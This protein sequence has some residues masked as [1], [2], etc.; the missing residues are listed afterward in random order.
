MS[1]K[2][3]IK[4]DFKLISIVFAMLMGLLTIYV[5]FSAYGYDRNAGKIVTIPFTMMSG[6]VGRFDKN[7][8]RVA[9]DGKDKKGMALF[10]PHIKLVEGEYT[11]YFDY[12][13][14]QNYAWDIYYYKINR[15]IQRGVL[16]IA[17]NGEFKTVFR[18]ASEYTNKDF[19]FRVMYSGKGDFIAKSLNL[20]R[21][22]IVMKDTATINGMLLLL[23]VI[24]PFVLLIIYL[25][26]NKSEEKKSFFVASSLLIFGG[27][28]VLLPSMF[29]AFLAIV[30]ILY[31]YYVIRYKWANIIKKLNKFDYLLFAFM[32]IAIIGVIFADS[33]SDALGGVAVFLL[34][35]LLYIAFK[36]IAIGGKFQKNF[37]K[38]LSLS[39]ILWGG[40][41]VFHFLFI[42]SAIALD[43]FGN[44]SLLM[45]DNFNSG[46]LTAFFGYGSMGA[47]LVAIVSS[48]IMSFLISSFTHI[49][50][51]DKLIY[52]L[53]L[54]I[55][56][57]VIYLTGGRGAL[58]VFAVSLVINLVNRN[59]IFAVFAGVVFV[60]LLFIM[61]TQKI[62]Q[63]IK[64]PKNMPN[65]QTRFN[66]YNAGIEIFKNSNKITGIGLINF[67]NIY[68]EKYSNIPHWEAVDFIHNSYLS[69]LV[70]TGVLG[71]IAI[72]GFL[73]W[74]L[75][76]MIFKNMIFNK[77]N[78]HGYNS[79]AIFGIS[80]VAAFLLI[81]FFDSIF[82]NV[83]LGVW[84]WIAMGISLSDDKKNEDKRDIILFT[85]DCF[86]ED[87][88]ASLIAK[89]LRNLLKDKNIDCKLMG[90]TLVG[91]GKDYVKRGIEQLYAS[92]LP[93]SGGFVTTSF[94]AFLDDLFSGALFNPS[95]FRAAI[96]KNKKRIKIAVV[97]GDVFLLWLTKKALRGENIPIL[98]YVHSKTDYI[99]PHY[100]IEER[101]IRN[102]TSTVFARDEFSAGNMRKQNISAIFLGS[103]IMDELFSANVKIN[104]DSKLQTIGILPGTRPEMYDN[105]VMVLDVIE[106]VVADRKVNCISAIYAGLDIDML[107]QK[108][109]D[110]GWKKSK[111]KNKTIILT[112]RSAIVQLNMNAFVDVVQKSD[113]LIGL[114]GAGNEQ[115]VGL[116][117]PVISFVGTGA[118][119]TTRRFDEQERLLGG[120]MKFVRSYPD[121]V[122][123]TVISLLDDENERKRMGAIGMERMGPAGGALR[124]ATHILKNYLLK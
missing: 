47:Y 61:P 82:Y 73:I 114:S 103:I 26:K 32:L 33:K 115:A 23:V 121:A 87:R 70:E 107:V 94:K 108:A 122:V 105:F 19:E 110:A 30:L 11:L 17:N 2:E 85:S 44:I 55:G 22:C 104:L 6:Q 100:K 20:K 7:G 54:L 9:K 113:I 56:F 79:K 14:T 95:K 91:E 97:V 86:S 71:F 76:W 116:G 8:Y 1:K 93:P 78:K 118:Q 69:F 46:I 41:A 3:S 81:S 64:N 40:F 38:S 4:I 29:I 28:F 62:I 48:F 119:T 101:F 102:T 72:F 58:L 24:I 99:E 65:L 111:D 49:K 39:L 112:K 43:F 35:T 25:I 83:P 124:I 74:Y 31:L 60:G 15:V 21:H 63:T 27:Y 18:I 13:A 10:G 77:K 53:A 34:Y 96:Q 90:A 52:I 36:N 12:D 37:A 88:N 67:K 68:K 42:K 45:P 5:F 59:K 16:P 92:K 120:S 109:K 80:M 51:K 66:Q 98:F 84:I 50:T 123:D 106:L 57:A 89:N 75:G 117:K